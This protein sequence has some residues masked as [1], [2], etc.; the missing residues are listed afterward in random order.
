[1]NV[2]TSIED[3]NFAIA[4]KPVMSTQAIV[5]IALASASAAFTLGAGIWCLFYGTFGRGLRQRRAREGG[6]VCHSLSLRSVS[7]LYL[8]LSA[9]ASSNM[10]YLK[11]S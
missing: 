3:D 6:R 9:S 8:L 2:S 10:V 7:T 5:L 11:T 1:M 4:D